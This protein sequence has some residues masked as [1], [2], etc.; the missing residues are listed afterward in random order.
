MKSGPIVRDCRPAFSLPSDRPHVLLRHQDGPHGFNFMAQLYG[1]TA[2][3]GVWVLPGSHS[4]GHRHDIV[5]MEELYGDRFPGSLPMIAGAGDVCIANRMVLHCSYPN[6]SH[7]KRITLNMGWQTSADAV[8]L[9]ESPQR[10]RL[11]PIA[12]AA[13]AARYPHESSF[14]VPQANPSA[15]SLLEGWDHAAR[16]AV[17]ALS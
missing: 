14:V 15:G 1:S 17:S 4:G 9:N 12:I 10:S 16:Q 11:L 2:E 8:E 3:N 6:I 13:R 7:D 5:Q